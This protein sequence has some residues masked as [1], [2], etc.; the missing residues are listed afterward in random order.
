MLVFVE[1]TVT[2]VV[3][4]R[5]AVSVIVTVVLSCLVLGSFCVVNTVWVV[6]RVIFVTVSKDAGQEAVYESMGQEYVAERGCP[7]ELAV[8]VR[9]VVGTGIVGQELV[10][11]MLEQTWFKTT[12]GGLGVFVSVTSSP[13]MVYAP[14][15]I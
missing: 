8:T 3:F 1:V 14:G 4:V 5:V 9:V 11:V 12:N 6:V 7:L 2:I 13:T 15:I 10:A